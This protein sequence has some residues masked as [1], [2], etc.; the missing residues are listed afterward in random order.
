MNRQ[1]GEAQ[2]VL[3]TFIK[4]NRSCEQIK[5]CTKICDEITKN[6]LPAFLISALIVITLFNLGSIMPVT[7]CINTL[8]LMRINQY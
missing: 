1:G 3:E 8:L 5:V 2:E 6:E 4:V 7:M